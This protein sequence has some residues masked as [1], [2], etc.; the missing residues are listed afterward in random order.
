MHCTEFVEVFP[1][2]SPQQ[3]R[4]IFFFGI[5]VASVRFRT[6]CRNGPGRAIPR[7]KISPTRTVG[8]RGRFA[9]TTLGYAHRLIYVGASMKNSLSIA[10]GAFLLALI[11]FGSSACV[12]SEREGSYDRDHH[13]YYHENAWHDCGERDEHCH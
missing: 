13:R 4:S 7:C 12:V 11:A 1:S 10:K 3:S 5:L 8:I 2:C 6:K 9:A